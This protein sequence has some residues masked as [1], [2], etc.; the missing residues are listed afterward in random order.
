[1][2]DGKFT[3]FGYQFNRVEEKQKEKND[4]K[5]TA[6]AS[7]TKDDGA[8]SI[9][10]SS[11]YGTYVD[12]DGSAKSDSELV[13][14][15]REMTL[16]AEIM[17]AVD[18]ITNECIV[19]EDGERTVDL[20][21]DE[22][23]LDSKAKKAI[24]AEFDEIIRLLE[25]NT[26]AYHIFQRWFIDGRLYYNVVIDKTKP[27]LGI[28]ELRYI[29]PR[30]IKKVREV[31][32]KKQ[33]PSIDKQNVS[34]N[35]TVNEY[36]IYNDSGLAT[37]KQLGSTG[38]SGSTNG[39]KIAKD[40][41][42]QVTS[43]IMDQNNI[44]VLG[45]L[46][47][48]IKPLNQLRSLED[49]TLIYRITRA[50]ERRIF[51]IDVSNMPKA[52]A[53]QYLRE[54]MIRHK[55]KVVYDPANGEIRDSRKFTTMLEDFWLPRR[56]GGKGTEISTLPAGQSLGEIADVLYFQKKL[57][58]S[59]WIPYSR[60]EGDAG[61]F[62]NKT[63][64]ITRDEIKFSKFVDRL[65][66]KFSELFLYSLEKQL[67]LKGLMT[68][69]EFKRLQHLIKFRFLRD[70]YFAENKDQ[71]IMLNR[72]AALQA[73]VPFVGKY[74]SNKYIMN[75]ILKLTDEDIE[76]MRQDIIN[77]MQDPL[78]NPPVPEGQEPEEPQGQKQQ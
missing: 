9:A 61:M 10:T 48:A 76:R 70:N 21:L 78:F 71:E 42:V 32:K 18:E 4:D 63:S 14:K 17:S 77:E 50:P 56:D 68:L 8:I 34:L 2:A 62:N 20:V 74:Y 55:N 53:E 7:E 59:L 66:N 40:A 1:M 33:N 49:A 25:F 37:Q 73:V 3:L 43:G 27:E 22:L 13:S 45:Y 11:Q 16:N 52:K 65:R 72:L 64:E 67:V 26:K 46:H 31:A 28:L 69:E 41:V 47:P 6:F 38:T 44:L 29:D 51:Y 39:L 24:S 54:Q 5:L 12:Q 36:F 58:K 75:H 30:K 60:I 19:M 57:Y 15:Y 23:P 35:R